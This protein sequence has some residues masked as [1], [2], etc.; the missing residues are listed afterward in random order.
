LVLT[1]QKNYVRLV[2]RPENLY[3]DFFI[4]QLQP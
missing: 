4:T 2:T 3:R 1:R